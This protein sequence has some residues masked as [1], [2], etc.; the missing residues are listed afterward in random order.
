MVEIYKAGSLTGRN[1]PLDHQIKQIIESTFDCG[2]S[3]EVKLVV[4]LIHSDEEGLIYDLIWSPN[5]NSH[6]D[7]RG[8]SPAFSTI[9]LKRLHQN[10]FKFSVSFESLDTKLIATLIIGLLRPLL[11]GFLLTGSS[12]KCTFSYSHNSIVFSYIQAKINKIMS[13][14]PFNLTDQLVTALAKENTFIGFDSS[15]RAWIY[16][17]NPAG[18][19]ALVSGSNHQDLQKIYSIQ[20]HIALESGQAYHEINNEGSTIFIRDYTKVIFDPDNYVDL[21][22]KIRMVEPRKP[23]LVR[24]VLLGNLEDAYFLVQEYDQ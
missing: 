13:A 7:L 5:A 3:D 21:I 10:E 14:D 24:L 6:A 15:Q 20:P 8:S 22:K 1:R 17:Q 23:I 18:N 4:M 12:V 19:M 11:K 16:Y 9:T 2:E